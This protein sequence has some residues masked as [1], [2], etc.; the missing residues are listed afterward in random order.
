MEVRCECDNLMELTDTDNRQ[1]WIEETY[2]CDE[3]GKTKTHR[4]EFD[5]IGLVINDEIYDEE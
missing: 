4:T 5:Q 1:E 3:C 2:I